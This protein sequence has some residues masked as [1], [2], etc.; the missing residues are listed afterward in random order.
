MADTENINKDKE[1]ELNFFYALHSNDNL[2]DKNNIEEWCKIENY[3]ILSEFLYFYVLLHEKIY[4][5][6]EKSEVEKRKFAN[7]LV[8]TKIYIL[9]LKNYLE[10]NSIVEIDLLKNMDF[11]LD[12]LN[13]EINSFQFMDLSLEEKIEKAYSLK[14]NNNEYEKFMKEWD[15]DAEKSRKKAQLKDNYKVMDLYRKWLIENGYL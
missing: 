7:G 9:G 13:H 11:Y 4:Q 8:F 10:D 5:K 2:I 1:R 14:D 6:S 3:K 15:E 12:K